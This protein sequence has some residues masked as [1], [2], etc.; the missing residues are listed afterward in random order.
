M[1]FPDTPRTIYPLSQAPVRPDIWVV[2]RISNVIDFRLNFFCDLSIYSIHS[3]PVKSIQ[4]N[5]VT[6][7]ALFECIDLLQFGFNLS[8]RFSNLIAI[9]ISYFLWFDN[10]LPKNGFLF[11]FAICFP[12]SFQSIL[13]TRSAECL[14]ARECMW[15]HSL[16]RIWKRQPPLWIDFIFYYI[17]TY[18]R[19]Y[20]LIYN[21]LF[22]RHTHHR[23][24]VT[25]NH[26]VWSELNLS[27]RNT[28]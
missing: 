27:K 20:I 22:H 5:R 24:T 1:A 17:R 25:R 2:Q 23:S 14:C 11:S 19:T 4:Q 18:V 3:W 13:I 12:F 15:M 8:I 28:I 21:C 9:L 6:T 16:A 26:R 10:I 7:F